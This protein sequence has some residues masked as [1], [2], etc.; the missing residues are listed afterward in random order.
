MKSK[1][2]ENDIKHKSHQNTNTVKITNE[3]SKFE[4]SNIHRGSALPAPTKWIQV[5]IYVR[6]KANQPT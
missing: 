1:V 5:L 2:G 3:I 6:I 4:S